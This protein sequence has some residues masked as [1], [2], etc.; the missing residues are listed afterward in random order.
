MNP[1][2]PQELFSRV[3]KALAHGEVVTVQ[4]DIVEHVTGWAE[5]MT[6]LNDHRHEF[7]EE[8]LRRMSSG[9]L[10]GVDQ[11]PDQTYRFF[12]ALD[13]KELLRPSFMT[14]SQMEAMLSTEDPL[15]GRVVSCTRS[16]PQK[17][18]RYIWSFS[19]L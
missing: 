19:L 16:S 8:R 3:V 13:N 18:R 14:R 15:T 11:L 1:V 2:S 6:Q 9:R 12:Y 4:Y 7:P 5:L 10:S 17:M